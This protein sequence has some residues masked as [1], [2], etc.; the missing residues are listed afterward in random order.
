V[1]ISPAAAGA[2]AEPALASEAKDANAEVRPV[3]GCAAPDE[4][5]AGADT[6][7]TEPSSMVAEAEEDRDGVGEEGRL[8]TCCS[9]PIRAS[10]VDCLV[11][12]EGKASPRALRVASYTDSGRGRDICAHM[13]GGQGCQELVPMVAGNSIMPTGGRCR[14]FIPKASYTSCQSP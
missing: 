8:R 10:R 11:M 5:G 14:G 13:Q 9:L 2:G 4:E 12:Q 6:S 3:L 7:A 1:V